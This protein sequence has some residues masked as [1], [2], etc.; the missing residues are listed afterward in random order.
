MNSPLLAPLAP[1]LLLLQITWG[2]LQLKRADDRG[3][4]TEMIII[5]AILAAVALAVV[6]LIAGAIETKGD[7]IKTDIGNAN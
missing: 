5:T 6:G 4:T 7:E 2:R 3:V 1:L